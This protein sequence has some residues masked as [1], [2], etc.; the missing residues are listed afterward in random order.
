[1]ST[2]RYKPESDGRIKVESKAEMKKRGLKSPNKRTPCACR[3]S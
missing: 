3:I 2:I 1:L